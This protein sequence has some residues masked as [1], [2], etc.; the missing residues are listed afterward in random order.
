MI[1]AEPQPDGA[2][3]ARAD[4][5]AARVSAAV[6]DRRVTAVMDT[7]LAITRTLVTVVA[8]SVHHACSRTANVLLIRPPNH[9][10]QRSGTGSVAR[11]RCEGRGG[12]KTTRN[13]LLHIKQRE[14][15]QATLRGNRTQSASDFVQ[16]GY[17][18]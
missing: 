9:E 7:P 2:V 15:I 18:K 3:P 12:Y 11:I 4:V 5:D 1:A 14:I 8:A 17:V 10:L 16:L 6:G 13:Y